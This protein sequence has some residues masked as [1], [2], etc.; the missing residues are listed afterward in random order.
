MKRIILI[1]FIVM[2]ASMVYADGQ[3]NIA[4]SPY[5]ISNPGSYIVVKDLTTP[6]DLNGI[7]I[8]ASNVTIDLNGHTLYGAG[9]TAGSSGSGI[10]DIDPQGSNNVAIFNGTIRDF[11]FYGILLQGNQVQVSRANVSYNGN[12]GIDLVY[13][14]SVYDCNA[15][16][17]GNAG[18]F[19]GLGGIIRNNN[20]TNNGGI[21]IGTMSGAINGNYVANNQYCGIEAN[22]SLVENNNVI[23][24]YSIGISAL[25]GLVKDN[26]VTYN[27]TTGIWVQNATLAGN[28]SYGNTLMDIYTGTGVVNENGTFIITYSPY[29]ITQPG[30]YI[31]VKDLT[32]PQ[33]VNGITIKADNVTLDLNGHTLTGAGATSG[34]NGNGIVT[35]SNNH[36]AVF[37]GIICSF[38]SDGISLFGNDCRVNQITAHDNGEWGIFLNENGL[39]YDNMLFQNNM[40]FQNQD[41]GGG[42]TIGP[43]GVVR[44]NSVR[45]NGGIGIFVGEGTSIINN[46]ISGNTTGIKCYAQAG[47]IKDNT[48]ANNSING[49]EL[50]CD[51]QAVGN[52][53]KYNGGI[54]I[55]AT[56]NG[57]FIGQNLCVSNG[58]GLMCSSIQAR[59]YV[60]QNKLFDN[61]T[62]ENLNGSTEGA[63]VLANVNF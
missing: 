30:S 51:S 57:N 26:N 12:S 40:N 44:N 50:W 53:C 11:R 59:N 19:S 61:T 38:K 10:F 14:G 22:I 17:N 34:L 16:F 62:S 29:T 28:N 18:I 3:I 8:M 55:Y 31:V 47:F 52:I 37:N 4:Y 32:T 9:T 15:S 24:N 25:G 13:P 63:G 48:V 7:T 20:V 42:I 27:Q 45:N 5:T 36:I 2:L 54:G 60:E 6:Q 23:S 1:I 39:V 43:T 35:W 41:N 56:G 33:N 21:G 46:S 58:T 49:I